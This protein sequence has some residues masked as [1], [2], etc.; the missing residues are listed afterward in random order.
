[1]E[2]KPGRNINHD[3]TLV[4]YIDQ[5][6]VIGPHPN[7]K[8]GWEIVALYVQEENKGRLAEHIALSLLRKQNTSLSKSQV[9]SK[10]WR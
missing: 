7:C 4:Y 5:N 2:V 3:Y 10:V 8:Q 1:M 6:S 9:G